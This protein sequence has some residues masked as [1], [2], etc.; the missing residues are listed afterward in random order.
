MV[1]FVVVFLFFEAGFLNS[2]VALTILALSIGYY[3]FNIV[4]EMSSFLISL[5]GSGWPGTLYVDQ[6]S[7]RLIEI[8]LLLAPKC[9]D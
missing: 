1:I 3:Y 5:C 4:L 9:W 2:F 7:L 8:L 6:A